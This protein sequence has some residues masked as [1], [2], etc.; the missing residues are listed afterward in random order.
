MNSEVTFNFEQTFWRLGVQ[1]VAGIDEAGRGPLAGPVVAAA[2]IFPV[3]C[4]MEGVDDSKKLTHRR[5]EELFPRI[6]EHAVSVG[7]GIV[8][9]QDIDKMNILQA[10][11]KAMH[12][13]IASLAARPEHLL[14]DGNR[15][16]GNEVPFTTIVDGDARCHAIAAASIIAKVTRDRIMVEQ[17]TLYPEYGFA[18]HKG[19]GTAQHR[20]AIAQYGLCPIHRRSFCHNMQ[21]KDRIDEPAWPLR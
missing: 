20:A 10:T 4:F 2:V 9:Q 6:Q 12:I 15:F 17:D 5:R 13:A 1:R 18:R 11:F 8:D 21:R 7:I 16:T 14:V 3:G 19:Y